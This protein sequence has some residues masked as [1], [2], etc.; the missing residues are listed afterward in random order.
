MRRFSL[1][2]AFLVVSSLA[3]LPVVTQAQVRGGGP[4]GGGHAMISAPRA[5]ASAA[6][7]G[8]AM[9]GGGTVYRATPGH[10]SGAG[11]VTTT[12]RRT[13]SNRSAGRTTPTISTMS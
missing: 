7:M 8:H 12:G 4:A 3:V 2:V 5:S 11:T 6:P 13:F 10:V 1:A 9:G